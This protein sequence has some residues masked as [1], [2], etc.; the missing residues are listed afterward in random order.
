MGEKERLAGIIGKAEA[1]FRDMAAARGH[2][3]TGLFS[4]GAYDI[5]P[6]HLAFWLTFD[7]DGARDAFLA[8]AA[9]IGEMRAKLLDLG[10]P[11]EGVPHAGITAES[12]ETVDRD[13]EG[14]WWYAVK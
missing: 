3:V 7:R 5:H 8:D 10:Y 13:F 14:S 4:F 1:A 2:P 6:R 9:L 12:Q 11:A